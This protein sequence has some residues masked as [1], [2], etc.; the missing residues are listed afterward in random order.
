MLLSGRRRSEIRR[1]SFR[2]RFGLRALVWL[3][4]ALTI[5]VMLQFSGVTHHLVD[6]IRAVEGV[7]LH[8]AQI[9]CPYEERGDDC[10][11]GCPDCHCTHVLRALPA[12]VPELVGVCEPGVD[13]AL[14]YESTGP[15]C[16]TAHGLFRPPRALPIA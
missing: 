11:P 10:P 2:R 13:L 1:T 8:E 15:P 5:A 12:T 7:A 16:E 9:A 6:V 14:P 3:V 4:R